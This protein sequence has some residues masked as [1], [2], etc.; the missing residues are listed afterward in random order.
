MSVLQESQRVCREGDT[1]IPGEFRELLVR[2]LG[3]H[4]E[5]CTNPHYT[6]RLSNLWD[7]CMTLAR[8]WRKRS[9][10]G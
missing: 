2:M 7:K 9:S 8:S 6:A 1:D 10:M 3:H 5:N 4:L